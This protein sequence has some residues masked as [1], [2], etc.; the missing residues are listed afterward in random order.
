MKSRQG[1]PHLLTTIMLCAT[2]SACGGGGGGGSATPTPPGAPTIGAATAGNGSIAVSFTPPASSGSSPIVDYVATCTASGSTRSQT[3][4]TSPITVPGLTNGTT[5]S[6]S[7]T[8]TNA[9]GQCNGQCAL[10]L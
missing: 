3:G 5:Y 6:C 7:V 10:E 9:V 4:A 8:A 2:L 1:Q